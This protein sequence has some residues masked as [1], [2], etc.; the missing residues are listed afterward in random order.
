MYRDLVVYGIFP[1]SS[2]WRELKPVPQSD[3]LS[4]QLLTSNSSH[5]A[6]ESYEV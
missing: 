2:I 5:E 1:S 6:T 4:P 3:K